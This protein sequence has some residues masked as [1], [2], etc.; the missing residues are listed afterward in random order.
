MCQL[1]GSFGLQ[2]YTEVVHKASSQNGNVGTSSSGGCLRAEGKEM[3]GGRDKGVKGKDIL[4]KMGK[5]RGEEKG[6]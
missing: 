3:E 4:E 6:E 2:G 1:V 5:K